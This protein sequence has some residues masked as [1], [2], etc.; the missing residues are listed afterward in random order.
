[1]PATPLPAPLELLERFLDHGIEDLSEAEALALRAAL[2]RDAELRRMLATDLRHQARLHQAIIHGS[3]HVIRPRASLWRRLPLVS[4]LAASLL[5]GAALFIVVADRPESHPSLAIDAPLNVGPEPVQLRIDGR[6]LHV[7]PESSLLR[8]ADE[9]GRLRLDLRH[10]AVAFDIPANA[11]AI[12]LTAGNLRLDSD[13][14][15]AIERRVATDDTI[16]TDITLRRGSGTVWSG[17]QAIALTIDQTHHLTESR[18]VHRRDGRLV[19]LE[20]AAEADHLVLD[21]PDQS[22]AHG[23]LRIARSATVTVDAHPT[24]ARALLPGDPIDVTIDQSTGQIV[25]AHAHGGWYPARRLTNTSV[26]IDTG[27]AAGRVLPLAWRGSISE[28]GEAVMACV[29]RR[30]H[31]VINLLKPTS[32]WRRQFDAGRP[33]W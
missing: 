17:E 28:S 5:I 1:M 9:G 20:C 27:P 11:A 24:S 4:G 23:R 14:A 2:E 12:R 32:Q 7:G 6:A 16:R 3:L 10:G 26:Q 33:T 18:W 15:V 31:T 25:A 29:D 21:F 19:G 22:A 8:I 13:G 30:Q